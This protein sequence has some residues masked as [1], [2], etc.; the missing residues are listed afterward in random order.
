MSSS[1][2]KAQK[3]SRRTHKERHQPAFRQRMGLLEKHKDYVER[4]RHVLLLQI[5]QYK[6]NIWAVFKRFFLWCG[7]LVSIFVNQPWRMHVLTAQCDIN[8]DYH[9]K[10]QRIKKLQEKAAQRNPDEFYFKMIN[11]KTKNGM[12]SVFVLL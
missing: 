3:A 5:F 8:R 9:S 10:K 2:K 6:W 11:T 1:F 4:A 12:A 7:A